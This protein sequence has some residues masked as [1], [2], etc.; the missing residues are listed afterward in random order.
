MTLGWTFMTLVWGVTFRL[1]GLAML[2]WVAERLLQSKLP[3]FALPSGDGYSVLFF[4]CRF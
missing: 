1:L 4:F 2:C 3:N